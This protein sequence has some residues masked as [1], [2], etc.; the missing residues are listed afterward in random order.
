MTRRRFKVVDAPA[1]G[2]YRSVP[3]PGL[4]LDSAALLA[5]NPGRIIAVLQDGL[6]SPEHEVF[7]R[8]LAAQH[9]GG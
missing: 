2:I 4:W 8:R 3:F 9:K 1:D 5:D 7:V 6:Q